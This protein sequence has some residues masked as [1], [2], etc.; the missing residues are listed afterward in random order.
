MIKRDP[1]TAQYIPACLTHS[2]KNPGVQS[3][4]QNLHEWSWSTECA[5]VTCMQPYCLT[6]EQALIGLCWP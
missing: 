1:S 3:Y 5:G 6:I 2:H 4:C